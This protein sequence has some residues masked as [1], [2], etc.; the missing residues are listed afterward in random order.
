[1][2]ACRRPSAKREGGG[3]AQPRT[4]ALPPLV[5]TSTRIGAKQLF[6]GDLYTFLDVFYLYYADYVNTYLVYASTR[7]GAKRLFRGDLYT[8]SDV[9]YLYYADYV[10]TYLDVLKKEVQT[11]LVVC[12]SDE[13]VPYSRTAWYCPVWA[14]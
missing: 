7:I 13:L 9:F 11:G 10:N 12:L 1:M 6:R 3:A 5:Y 8:F 4:P 14:I 2:G